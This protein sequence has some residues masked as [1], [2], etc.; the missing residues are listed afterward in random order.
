MVYE[1]TIDVFLD[2]SGVQYGAMVLFFI[3]IAVFL[4][5]RNQRPVRVLTSGIHFIDCYTRLF[6]AGYDDDFDLSIRYK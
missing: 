4:K 3:G 1:P 2:F 5:Q 6:F